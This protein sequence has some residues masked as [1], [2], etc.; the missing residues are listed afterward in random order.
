MCYSFF[1]LLSFCYRAYWSVSPWGTCFTWSHPHRV[2]FQFNQEPSWLPR[3]RHLAF[4]IFVSLRQITHESKTSSG[5]KDSDIIHK[6][7]EQATPFFLLF[8]QLGTPIWKYRPPQAFN[9]SMDG[10]FL[11]RITSDCMPKTICNTTWMNLCPNLESVH[12]SLKNR[13]PP[14]SIS[15]STKTQYKKTKNKKNKKQT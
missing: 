15:Y 13:K 12:D 5:L 1:S 8:H 7:L 14:K 10:E 11:Y 3:Y 9:K 2:A 6:T 4:S